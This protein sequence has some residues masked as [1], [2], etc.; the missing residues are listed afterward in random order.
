MLL[1]R[2]LLCTP[3]LLA[4]CIPT[5][6]SMK[7]GEAPSDSI[8]EELRTEIADLR[9]EIQS[10]DV[11][12]KIL[13]D[14]LEAGGEKFAS[15]LE[16][17]VRNLS[18]KLA[19][20]EKTSE[21]IAADIRALSEHANQTSSSLGMYR[22]R[23]EEIDTKLQGNKRADFSLK[24]YRVKPGDSLEKIAKRHKV[25]LESLKKANN[26]SDDRIMIGQD[27]HIPDHG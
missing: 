21:K 12:L 3:L 23:I 27:L 10:K 9:H 26:L 7:N 5:L 20:L 6:T 1:T 24:S 18:R 4:G 8:L 17:Q 13:E 25:S 16:E 2:I 15:H 22:E 11:E 14:K 19:V